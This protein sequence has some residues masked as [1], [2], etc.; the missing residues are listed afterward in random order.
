MNNF[1]SKSYWLIGA[2]VKGVVGVECQFYE[3]QQHVKKICCRTYFKSAVGSEYQ[4]TG[5][6][7]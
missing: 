2:W 4:I 3:M 6:Q 1:A 5:Y 7:L